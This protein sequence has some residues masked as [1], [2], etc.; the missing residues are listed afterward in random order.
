MHTSLQY[1]M[2]RVSTAIFL[3]ANV[4]ALGPGAWMSLH[5]STC[6]GLV[7]AL[8]PITHFVVAPPAQV[9]LVTGCFLLKFL[10]CD[11]GI[12]PSEVHHGPHAHQPKAQKTDAQ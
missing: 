8:C 3:T 11:V 1:Q 9:N 5:P 6:N 7:N 2:D 12:D 10:Y 4:S